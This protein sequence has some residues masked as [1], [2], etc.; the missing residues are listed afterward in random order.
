M[1]KIALL[2]IA[3]CC[4]LHTNAQQKP[5]SVFLSAGQS[6]A[7]G[8]AY[9]SEG[10][11]DYMKG[12]YKHLH[13]ANVTS[14]ERVSFYDRIFD[15]SQERGCFA[16]SDVTNYY[17]DQALQQDFY[18]I[19]CAYG[20]TAIALG[21]TVGKLP[22]W[23]A[24]EAY[25]DTARAYRGTVGNG[26]SLAK[27][28]TEGFR[29]LADK[30]L[31][32]LSQGYD[33]KAILWHQGE[34]DRKAGDAYYDNLKD[35]ITF[36]RNEVYKVTGDEADLS[37]PFIMGTVPHS[38]KQFNSRVEAAQL[39]LAE[40]MTNVYTIDLGDAG[41]RSDN[42]H[43]NAEWTEYFGMRVYNQLVEIG[44]VEGQEV[45]I[46]KPDGDVVGK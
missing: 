43:F 2:F 9:L 36:I 37:L 13:F 5:A 25:I 7:D 19:K 28:M 24:E 21:Q 32:K 29:T 33:V 46:V 23:N 41:L 34:S 8:R 42:L 14:E 18:S 15:G 1:R 16:F 30:V 12:G 40:D 45:E 27:S 4:A 10:L 6:N 44:A 39:K 20:G 17:I 38:S 35:L 11:P 3:A 31:S 22:F 26:T